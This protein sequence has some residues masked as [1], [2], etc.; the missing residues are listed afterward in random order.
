[1]L[2]KVIMNYN[3]QPKFVHL[4]FIFAKNATHMVY[5]PTVKLLKDFDAGIV[6]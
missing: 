4:D 1:M 2:P 5:Q 3:V 6:P